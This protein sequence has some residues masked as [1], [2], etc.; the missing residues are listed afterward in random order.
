MYVKLL[1]GNLRKNIRDYGVFFFTVALASAVFY[2][3]NTIGL[4][5]SFLSESVSDIFQL[6]AVML[7]GLTVVLAVILGFL[8]VY[9]NNYLLK[10]RKK[11]FG[12]YELLGMKKSTVSLI[13]TGETLICFLVALLVGIGLG[14]IISQF[15]IFVS[16]ALFQN[17]IT[18][19]HF[20]FS[21]DAL[22]LVI[23]CFAITFMVTVVLNV[24][25]LRRVNLEQLLKGS[26]L[27][28]EQHLR[29]KWVSC[30]VGML[31]IGFLVSACIR[32]SIQGFPIEAINQ[33]GI[34]ELLDFVLT[35]LLMMAGVYAIFFAV[36]SLFI[37]I[38]THARRFYYRGLRMFTIRQVA[39]RITS[40]SLSMGTVCLVLFLAITSVST[41]LGIAI[42]TSADL[43]RTVPYTAT[44]SGS[45][46]NEE[47]EYV[48][49]SH[50]AEEG[51]PN[52]I[53]LLKQ[54]NL[55]V[56]K[57]NTNANQVNFFMDPQLGILYQRVLANKD[58]K[59]T[60]SGVSQNAPTLETF[61]RYATTAQR[62]QLTASLGSISLNPIRLEPLS[63][64]NATCQLLGKPTIELGDDTYAMSANA[65]GET[66][67]SVLETALA[68]G[69]PIEAGGTKLLP[70]KIPVITDKTAAIANIGFG[71]N[72]ST[73]IVPDKVAE[74]CTPWSFSLQLL[75]PQSHAK[76]FQEYCT[77]Q[78]DAYNEQYGDIN[79]DGD[80]GTAN[81]FRFFEGL[82]VNITLI[83]LQETI[84]K[85][86][87]GMTGLVGYLAA[88]I[89]FVLVM[90][91]A[92][93]VAIQM[94]TNVS[95]STDRYRLLS[96]LGTPYAM[97]KRTLIAQILF[98]FMAPLV[99]GLIVAFVALI[100]VQNVA[101]LLMPFS[102]VQSSLV[103][104]AVF[105]SVYGIYL[106]L[107]YAISKG[108]VLR[109]L[110]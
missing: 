90:S 69:C 103:A 7:R 60:L 4:Q 52:I 28:E 47:G 10:R 71:G 75:T 99:L 98:Y 95:D 58:S 81:A 65:G 8:M 9:A 18:Q 5:A 30:L 37:L 56:T 17:A 104:A 86:A 43:E 108:Y 73:L 35:T 22:W 63:A 106:A 45:F 83:S 93:I 72:S 94:L 59:E 55:D 100:Q 16:A 38:A 44:I 62:Q 29:N 11:E 21:W 102:I 25:T 2:A 50:T 34:K 6:M 82:P 78:E 19:F 66:L 77:A 14:V 31:G 89:G 101:S 42:G 20:I 68:Q 107:C 110:S 91:V 23:F 97:L 88:Y 1:I 54:H 74:K 15:L 70:L 48:L 76:A 80:T 96:D 79:A 109:A 105:L 32:F 27:N 24:I 85:E 84:A 67:V 64:Y 61:L 57:Y 53:D 46:T 41:G 33:G 36:P 3:F 87:Q 39:S 92:A 49:N 12:L 13:M 26:R 51:L 40:N